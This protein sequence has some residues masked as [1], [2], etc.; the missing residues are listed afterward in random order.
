MSKASASGTSSTS[1]PLCG[2]SVPGASKPFLASALEEVASPSRQTLVTQRSGNAQSAVR[3]QESPS[4]P[5]RPLSDV[6]PRT[7][8]RG[9]APSRATRDQGHGHEEACQDD[10]MRE[11]RVSPFHLYGASTKSRTAG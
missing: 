6:P 11:L 5:R 3:R 4:D 9:R 10:V 1:A 8:P 2:R 7:C